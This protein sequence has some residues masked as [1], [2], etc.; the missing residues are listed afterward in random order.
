[1]PYPD[2]FNAAAFDRAMGTGDGIEDHAEAWAAIETKAAELRALLE[3]LEPQ[4]ARLYLLDDAFVYLDQVMDE[5][6]G[7]ITKDIDQRE[8]DALEGGA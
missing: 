7:A 4:L 2:N 5:I 8:N 3:A 6:K 1:M